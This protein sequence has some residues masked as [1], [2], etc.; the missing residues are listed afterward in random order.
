[1]M[2]RAKRRD[3]FNIRD[4][5]VD[6]WQISDS[7]DENS[8]RSEAGNKCIW[9]KRKPK[10][11]GGSVW[12]KYKPETFGEGGFPSEWDRL[13][14]QS[15]ELRT[16]QPYRFLQTPKSKLVQLGSDNLVI[17]AVRQ[18]VHGTNQ[19]A[20]CFFKQTCFLL[21]FCDDVVRFIGIA[22]PSKTVIFI[23]VFHGWMDGWIINYHLWSIWQLILVYL[24]MHTHCNISQIAYDYCIINLHFKSV[25]K[26]FQN[27]FFL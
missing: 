6:I 26:R 13:Q 27:I 10:K 20:D 25:W 21:D 24:N 22:V 17:F 8:Y 14:R 12:W 2:K 4:G 19:Y 18:V 7:A 11:R 15:V 16:V 3:R 23:S 9:L 1:M 5:T